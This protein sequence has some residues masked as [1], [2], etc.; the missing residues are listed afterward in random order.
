MDPATHPSKRGVPRSTS[1]T[2]ACSLPGSLMMESN[3]LAA[4]PSSLLSAGEL[5]APGPDRA[6]P[7]WACGGTSCAASTGA[8]VRLWDP[9]TGVSKL[10]LRGHALAIKGLAFSPMGSASPCWA[11]KGR[12]ACGR[13]TSMT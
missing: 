4:S 6:A 2:N 10:V 1:R 11:A 13:S 12:S 5:S 8:T 7:A 9:D 3:T